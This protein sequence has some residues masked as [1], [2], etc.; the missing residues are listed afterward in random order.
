MRACT[1]S[2][3]CFVFVLVCVSMAAVHYSGDE[4]NRECLPVVG[5]YLLV[6]SQ[7]WT[8]LWKVSFYD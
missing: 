3:V 4:G 5:K 2:F 7:L 6:G 8:E 1:G